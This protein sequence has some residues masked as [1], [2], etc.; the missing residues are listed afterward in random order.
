MQTTTNLVL[1]KTLYNRGLIH[2]HKIDWDKTPHMTT[3]GASGTG[4]TFLN[5]LIIARVSMKI[6]N[7]SITVLDFKADDYHF[8]RSCKNLYEFDKVQEGLEAYYQE[9]LLRQQGRDT[10]RSF[11][12]LVI[13]ELGS[14]MGYFDKKVVESMKM[15]IANITFMG[16]SVN[17][18]LLVST[19]RP[20]TTYFKAGVRD[21]LGVV[22]ALGSLSK[23]GKSMMFNDFKDE[24][25]EAQGQGS[26]YL[27]NGVELYSIKVPHVK[28]VAKLE[29]YI[30]QAL[31]G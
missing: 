3:I 2:Y 18:H 11:K 16:R 14:M 23:E 4:K 13:E 31:N 25:T 19:Q 8:A 28:D 17:F 6:P 7:S 15:M 9:F 29:H 24:M 21:S 27:T 12:L 1:D 22:I 10:D 30:K 20:D 26:G 5:K